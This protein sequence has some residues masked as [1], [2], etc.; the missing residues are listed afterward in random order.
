MIEHITVLG[1]DR[2]QHYLVQQLML[3]GFEVSTYGVPGLSDTEKSL[4]KSLCQAQAVVLPMPAL[5]KEGWVRAEK[6]IPLISVLES[7][8]SGC[9][10][11]GGVLDGAAETLKTYPLQVYDY[12]K[13]PVL[14][15]GNAVPTAEGAIQ[16]AMEQLPVTL[17]AAHCLVIGYGRIGKVL[18]DRLQGLHADVTVTA[19]R[20]EDRALAA[21]M[22]FAADRT[23]DY[24]RGLR[25][26]D[27][28]FNTVPGPVLTREQLV[29][30][31]PDCLIIDLAT[32]GGLAVDPAS[33][34]R[35]VYRLEP[36]L[37]GR[38]SPKTAAE[39]I[40]RYILDTLMAK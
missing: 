7:L 12:A 24:L 39:V 36:G 22:G 3:S 9:I 34:T 16:I 17:A 1:G 20:P 8:Q 29:A 31:A 2:R 19:R 37:P 4:H 6:P 30:L 23:G 13:S 32:G 40:R 5:T 33:V 25:Q 26:Y 35:P 38:T 18:A 27:C 28:V 10:L 21:A 11:F 14:A 15:A